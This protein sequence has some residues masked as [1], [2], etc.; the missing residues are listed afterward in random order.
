MTW[1]QDVQQSVL[2]LGLNGQFEEG[3]EDVNASAQVQSHIAGPQPQDVVLLPDIF[4]R[5]EIAEVFHASQGIR[6]HIRHSIRTPLE[7]KGHIQ[8]HGRR[9][10]E[11]FG[12]ACEAIKQ[13][14]LLKTEA[15]HE[16]NPEMSSQG[17]RGH[18]YTSHSPQG[19]RKADVGR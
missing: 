4:L 2:G 18:Q 14:T 11:L 19:P 15:W 16:A 12:A 1:Q 7:D 10:L 13:R 17:V 9:A 8:I 5:L 6:G 3:Q